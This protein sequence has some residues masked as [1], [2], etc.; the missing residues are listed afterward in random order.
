MSWYGVQCDRD[1][2]VILVNISR[3]GIAGRFEYKLGGLQ[4]L[5]KLDVSHNKFTGS[6]KGFDKL[7]KLID[8]DISYNYFSGPIPT[9]VIRNM[10][11]VDYDGNPYLCCLPSDEPYNSGNL[12]PCKSKSSN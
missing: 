11:P 9:Y 3:L 4:A 2:N 5:Q 8:F 6:I 12:K 10:P 1:N 7:Q